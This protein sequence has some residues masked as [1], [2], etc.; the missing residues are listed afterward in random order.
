MKIGVLPVGRLPPE[1]PRILVRG[2]PEVFPGSTCLAVEKP[3]AVPAEAYVKR[4]GQFSS[5]VI[6]NAI[7]V[8]AL[9][10]GE[11]DRVLGVVD[12]DVFA[13]GLNFVFGEAYTPG[14]AA[15]ISLLRLKPSFYGETGGFDVFAGRVLKEAVHELGHTLGLSHCLKETCVMHFSN[16][17]SDTDKKESLFCGQD[18]LQALLAIKQFRETS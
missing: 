15:L 8:F 2:V 3:F 1:V 13:S 7:R 18:Y 14:E 17:V 11:F 6:L 4:R 10:H 12:V 9:D 16:S 5:S